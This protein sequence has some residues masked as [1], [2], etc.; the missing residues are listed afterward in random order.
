MFRSK[1]I[2]YFSIKNI[3]NYINYKTFKK[4]NTESNIILKIANQL[5]DL[6][7]YRNNFIEEFFIPEK[8]NL[9]RSI[10]QYLAANIY[11]KIL[12][13]KII[14]SFGQKV[15]LPLEKKMYLK[16]INFISIKKYS[17]FVLF[18]LLILKEFFFGISYF[19][20]KLFEYITKYFYFRTELSNSAYFVSLWNRQCLTDDNTNYNI[21]NWFKNFN[22]ENK[23][24]INSYFHNMKIKSDDEHKKYLKSPVNIL[25][26]K[27]FIFFLI[28]GL[29][30]I[31]FSF[32]SLFFLRWKLALLSKDILSKL[33]IQKTSNKYCF[34]EYL[35]NNSSWIYKPLWADEVEKKGSKVIMYFY[36]MN[37]ENIKKNYESIHLTDSF[38]NLC[39]WK[40]Y[41]AW[42]THHKII[43]KNFINFEPIKIEIVGPIPYSDISLDNNLIDDNKKKKIAIFDISL[44]RKSIRI[45]FNTVHEFYTYK[46]TKKFILDILNLDNKKEI[47]FY[48]KLKRHNSKSFDKDYINFI[49]S[50]KEIDNLK[51][52]DPEISAF[53]L[54]EFCDAA[55]SLPFTST[56]QVFKLKNKT[57]FYYDPISFFDK[58]HVAARGINILYYEDLKKWINNL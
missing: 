46:T 41:Y 11:I 16:L 17:S 49:D 18:A 8:N 29:L 15:S 33:I 28:F 37:I 25:E 14:S 4:K 10:S 47:I 44:Y 55:I 21:Y 36:S 34:K 38:W 39:T 19:F 54:T 23:K 50:L 45:Y 43:L 6:K 42:N 22:L 12:N 57:S 51:I 27:T 2:K 31:F 9:D 7:F 20:L 26:F 40:N 35:F 24:N 13:K 30:L 32:V 1:L 5:S 48:L 3:R 56:A 52:V 58:Q 53:K